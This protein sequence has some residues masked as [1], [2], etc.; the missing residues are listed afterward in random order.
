MPEPGMPEHAGCLARG[1]V[2]FGDDRDD[3]TG[4]WSCRERPFPVASTDSGPG[5]RWWQPGGALF[6]EHPHRFDAALAQS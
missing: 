6:R 1:I 4:E 5:R 2:G 3:A